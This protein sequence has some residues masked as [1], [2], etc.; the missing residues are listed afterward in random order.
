MPH[1]SQQIDMLLDSHQHVKR[2]PEYRNLRLK[3]KAMK[4]SRNEL[5]L[6]VNK[7]EITLKMNNTL[8]ELVNRMTDE[9]NK[10]SKKSRRKAEIIESESGDEEPHNI[11]DASSSQIP[12]VDSGVHVETPHSI[13]S[14]PIEDRF[15]TIE[16]QIIAED[17]AEAYA[18]VEEVAVVFEDELAVAS[19]IIIVT[20]IRY[21]C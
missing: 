3:Y 12:E 15:D 4:K 1:L 11:S 21:C 13:S 10:H 8:V 14:I 16:D 18:D 5:L 20:S 9:A 6:L 17:E 7:L 2:S 19:I